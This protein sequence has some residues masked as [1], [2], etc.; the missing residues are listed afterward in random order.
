MRIPMNLN[1]WSLV[2]YFQ[3]Y[4]W[5]ICSPEFSDEWTSYKTDKVCQMNT[6]KISDRTIGIKYLYTL[7]SDFSNVFRYSLILNRLATNSISKQ[8]FLFILPALTPSSS[9]ISPLLRLEQWSNPCIPQILHSMPSLTAL[10]YMKS[11]SSENPT[12]VHS[13]LSLVPPTG[14]WHLPISPSKSCNFFAD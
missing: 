10:N 4:R 12:C 2:D 7:A 1:Q 5:S 8:L 6:G 3:K 11:S 13:A 14:K 9:L